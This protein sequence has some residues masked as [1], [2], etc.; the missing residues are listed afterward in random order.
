MI[1]RYMEKS[2]AIDEEVYISETA[3]IIGDVTLK[4]NS[5]IW[6]GSVLRGDMESIVIGE[7]TNI[8]ENSVVHV[9]KN[10]KVVVG[11]NCTI[12]HNAVIHGCIIGDNTL[13]G[14]GAIILNGVKIGKNS[15]VGAGALVTQNKE[16]EDGVL[17]LGNPAK[18]IRKLTE[19]EIKSNSQSSLNYIKLSKEME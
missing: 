4:R 16:F 19:E 8:Q 2:P 1:K 11:D 9:D 15:I 5:N 14:M 18:V 10:E 7:N 12:G 6:F 17:I 13:I 3:V